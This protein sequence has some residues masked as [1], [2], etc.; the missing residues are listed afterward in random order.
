M[1]DK[2]Y[3]KMPVKSIQFSLFLL[4][5]ALLTIHSVIPAP[6]QVRGKLQRESRLCPC[7]GR[8]PLR[9]E[10]LFRQETWIPG[11]ARNDKAGRVSTQLWTA[12]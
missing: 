12:S 6:Y 2:K 4:R 1:V 5:S 11:Q 7:E 10:F 3:Y 9:I 8:E